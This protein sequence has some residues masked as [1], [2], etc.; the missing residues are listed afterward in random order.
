MAAHPSSYPLT[1]V[2]F[3]ATHAP[4]P[5]AWA[6]A[7]RAF[8]GTRV[9]PLFEHSALML[10]P[11]LQHTGQRFALPRSP[12]I[13]LGRAATLTASEGFGFGHPFVA[14]A[15][16]AGVISAGRATL[17]EPAHACNTS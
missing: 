10:L 7:L 8:D 12:Y 2:G 9:H 13:H 15:A 6:S 16:C 5:L 3:V 14:P 4:G 17:G 11:G 1:A